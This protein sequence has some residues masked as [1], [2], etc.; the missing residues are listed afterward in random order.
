MVDR[1][2]DHGG[3]SAQLWRG[4]RWGSVTQGPDPDLGQDSARCDPR[5]RC[6][7]EWSPI[8]CAGVKVVQAR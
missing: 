7:G 2:H 8:P 5:R 3:P 4:G 1:R 6:G